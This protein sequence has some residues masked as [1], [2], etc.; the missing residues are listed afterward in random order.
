M[1]YQLKIHTFLMH[2]STY[3]KKKLI[4]IEPWDNVFAPVWIKEG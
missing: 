1:N 4:D 2:Y 3:N